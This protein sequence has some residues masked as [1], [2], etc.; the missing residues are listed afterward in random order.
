MAKAKRKSAAKRKSTPKRKPAH[1][2]LHPERFPNESPAYRAARNALLKAE[3]G[4]RQQVESVAALR[5]RLPLGGPVPEDY[6]FEE[7]AADLDDTGTARKVKMSELFTRDASLAVYSYMYGPA[8]AK[9]CPMCTSILDAL[10]RTVPHAGQRINVVVVAKSP[11]QRIRALARE[12]GWRNLRLLSSAGNGY[13][14]DYRG[15]D[16]GGAQLPALNVFARRNGRIHHLWCSELMFAPS[17]PGQN[18]RHV[19]MMWPLWNLFDF[20]PEGRGTD[21]YPKLAYGA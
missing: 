5:R 13:N 14:R 16:A 3:I 20:T 12:R 7:V 21:W 18:A 9:A 8:M 15:E 4:L 19:D 6:E 1:K 10:D 11:I 17:E 2:A